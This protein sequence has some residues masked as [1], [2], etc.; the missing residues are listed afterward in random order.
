M[1]RGLQCVTST[2]IA[3]NP[4]P[5]PI[6]LKTLQD[7][8]RGTG[9]PP[10]LPPLSLIQ[11]PQQHPARGGGMGLHWQDWLEDFKDFMKGSQVTDPVQQLIVLCNLIGKEVGQIIKELLTDTASSYQVAREVINRKFHHKMNI[12][13]KRYSFNLVTQERDESMGEFISPLKRLA[14]YVLLTCL[15]QKTL[16]V[17][18]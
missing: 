3:R 14:R 6:V 15:R 13:Y 10:Q 16:F 9:I 2:A 18:V 4:E 1:Q 12:D 7:P 5:T 8:G 11:P 17:Y